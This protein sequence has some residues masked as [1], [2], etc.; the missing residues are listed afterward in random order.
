ML[1]P[2]GT[3][4]A[5]GTTDE[6]TMP[7]ASAQASLAFADWMRQVQAGMEDVLDRFLPRPRWCRRACTKPCATPPGWRQARAPAAGLCRRRLFDA[8]RAL[9]A[10]RRRPWR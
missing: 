2:F 10:G 5:G 8:P 9:L 6:C 4:A 3:D 1:K 7:A